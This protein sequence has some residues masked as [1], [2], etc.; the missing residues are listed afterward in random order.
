MESLRPPPPCAKT[1]RPADL[2][3]GSGKRDGAV[4][5]RYASAMTEGPDPQHGAEAAGVAPRRLAFDCI[6]EVL[7]GRTALADVFEA[8]RGTAGLSGR[9]EALARAIATVAF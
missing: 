9:D 7:R 5:E 8:R 3:A 4:Q 2:Q 1:P 6:A